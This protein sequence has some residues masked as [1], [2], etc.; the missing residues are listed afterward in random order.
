VKN[1]QPSS[2]D[3]AA[4]VPLSDSAQ[5]KV[6]LFLRREAVEKITGLKCSSIYEKMQERTFPRPINISKRLVVWL[7]SDVAAWQ[8]A[9]IAANKEDA[10]R[11]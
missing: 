1:S 2:A 5:P 6:Q 11:R 7:E 3:N 10:N 4:N 9:Q 8:A